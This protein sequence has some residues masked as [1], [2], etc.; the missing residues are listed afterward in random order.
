MRRKGIKIKRRG[1]KFGK[2]EL[3]DENI[4]KEIEE[5]AKFIEKLN[6]EERTCHFLEEEA[7]YHSARIEYPTIKEFIEEYLNNSNKKR[8]K[9]RIRKIKKNLMAALSFG[10]NNFDCGINEIFV[11]KIGG[12]IE[13]SKK[14]KHTKLLEF[15]KTGVKVDF[16]TPPYPGKLEKELEKYFIDVNLLLDLCKIERVNP[17][18]VAGFAHFHFVRIHPFEDGNG[19]TARTL[20]NIILLSYGYPP[21]V[22]KEGERVFYGNLIEDAIKGRRER[23]ATLEADDIYQIS[24]EEKR[25]YNYIASKVNESFDTIIESTEKFKNFEKG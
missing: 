23:S 6:P 21:A 9:S 8:R 18:E 19:R 7:Q 14:D 10:L 17:C 15:R 4:L 1:V 22:I 5:K 24:E 25:F 20:Q 2:I 16:Y 11:K 13:P 12:K 3:V